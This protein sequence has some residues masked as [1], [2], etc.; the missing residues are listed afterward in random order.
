MLHIRERWIQFHEL[1]LSPEPPEA[2]SIKLR[3]LVPYLERLVNDG[4]AY[5]EKDKGKSAFRVSDINVERR[6]GGREALVLLLQYA[7]KDATDP[8]FADLQT[9]A[10]RTEPKLD[11]EGIAVSAH[12]VISMDPIPG[13]EDRYHFLL[14]S[15][16]GLGRSKI[17][18]FLKRQL[19][20]ASEGLFDF[21]DEENGV[22]KTYAPSLALL[23]TPSKSFLDEMEAGRLE[24]VELIRRMPAEHGIDEEGYFFEQ[25]YT[26][27][28][29]V[30]HQGLIGPDALNRLKRWGRAQGFD[31]LR[32]RYKKREGKQK[33]VLMGTDLD[34]LRDALVVKDELIS[35]EVELP[36]CSEQIIQWFSGKMIDMLGELNREA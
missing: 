22:R 18:P 26:L 14:E 1:V 24:G 33:S 12:A 16:P 21:I 20:V 8:T 2:P 15:V 34:D 25:T 13:K 27:K 10:L 6:K 23:G 19:K 4:E 17:E 5:Q 32:V 36:Q 3:D 29:S 7:D 35:S 11:G 28:I 30:K 9:G 31:D